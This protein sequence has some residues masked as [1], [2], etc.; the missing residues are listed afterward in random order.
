MIIDFHTHTFPERIAERALRGLRER[1]HTISFTDGTD[2]GLSE[3]QKKAGIDWSVILPVATNAQQPA[4]IN[5]TVIALQQERKKLGLLSFGAMH[6]DTVGWEEEL[7]RLKE[8]G[9]RGIKIH[10]VYQGVDF[11]D[12]RYVNILKVC[13]EL[14]L[15]VIIHA[16]RDIGFPGV[17]HASVPLIYHA[18]EKAGILNGQSGVQLILAHMGGW[19]EW[20]SVI[21]H[22]KDTPV[23]L[24]SSFSENRIHPL[25]DGYWE[26]KDTSMLSAEQFLR[27]KEAFGAD[28]ILFASDSPWSDQSAAVR[29]IKN[30]PLPEE[31]QALILGKNAKKLLAL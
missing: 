30:L 13:G 12:D 15:A 25:N 16:G 22:F 29:W 26:A 9:V 14:G 1:S 11:D 18:M 4:K 23:L 19:K 28:R 6:P 27:M 10:P 31:E 7:I 8:N 2:N 21:T 3:S 17:T 24:D 20:E 5:A